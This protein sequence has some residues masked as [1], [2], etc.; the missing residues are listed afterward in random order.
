MSA[1]ITMKEVLDSHNL[2]RIATLDS[3]G[4]PAVRAVGYAHGDKENILYFITNKNSRKI[5]HLQENSN[6][7]FSIDHD[8]P[9]MK[10]LSELKYIKGNGIARVVENPDE[11]SLAFSLLQKKFPFLAD[12]PGD[13]KDFFGVKVELKNVIVTDNTIKFGHTEEITF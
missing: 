12:L 3:D 13:P 9:T 11:A 2:M 8:C 4:I 1:Q 10:E 5:G 6:I 7:A